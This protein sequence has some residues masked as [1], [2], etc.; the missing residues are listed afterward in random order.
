MP[1]PSGSSFS[2]LASSPSAFSTQFALA[3]GA[4]L[5]VGLLDAALVASGIAGASA[6]VDTALLPL[7]PI[8]F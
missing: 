6:S 8:P 1:V 7:S 5:I 4:A 3:A 2:R